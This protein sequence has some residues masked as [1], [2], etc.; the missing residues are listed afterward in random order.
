ME[1]ESKSE[2][3]VI[4]YYSDDEVYEQNTVLSEQKTMNP[5]KLIAE[6]IDQP[7][8]QQTFS[9]FKIKVNIK[10]PLLNLK[11]IELTIPFL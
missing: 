2:V 8:N 3:S 7:I 11:Q 6:S 4:E 9:S 10:P 1:V 5:K